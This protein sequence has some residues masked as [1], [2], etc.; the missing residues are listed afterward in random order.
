MK[1][2]IL[3]Y[4]DLEDFIVESPQPM[5]IT[6]INGK[7]IFVNPA[8][9][10]LFGIDDEALSAIISSE[11]YVNPED[12]KKLQKEMEQKG[13]VKNFNIDL[14]TKD[15]GNI[16]ALID[17]KQVKRGNEILYRGHIIDITKIKEL[18]D[19]LKKEAILDPLTK[20]YNRRGLNDK[21][22]T[23]KQLAKAHNHPLSLCYLDLDNFK[24]YN[25]SFGHLQ[26][27]NA[28]IASANVLMK[29]ARPGD[30]Y[31]RVGGEEFILILPE[32]QL[33]DAE[34]TAE[35]LRYGIEKTS[36]PLVEKLEHSPNK[37]YPHDPSKITISAGLTSFPETSQDLEFLLKEADIAMYRA[38]Q[39]GR[40][41][42]CV[43]DPQYNKNGD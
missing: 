6:D 39:E 10:E 1:R 3:A 36:I 22:E 35:I 2:G 18:Q 38:K 31:G 28:L 5:Y 41:R 16:H 4:N 21:F 33:K 26:G 19:K 29:V 14:H 8:F 17:A 13:F 7:F 9:K 43:Y 30:S 37:K 32:T 42:V 24:K 25:D 34:E 27:D 12:R 23:L 15:K 40:N 11:L 20:L